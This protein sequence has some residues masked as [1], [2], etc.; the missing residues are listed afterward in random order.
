MADILMVSY[1]VERGDLNPINLVYTMYTGRHRVT[2]LSSI[3]GM[4]AGTEG[5][6]MKLLQPLSANNQTQNQESNSFSCT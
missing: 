3:P 1:P 2:K 4:E 6:I 5:L